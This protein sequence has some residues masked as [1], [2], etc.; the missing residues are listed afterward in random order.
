MK[1]HLIGLVALLTLGASGAASAQTMSYAEAG[2]LIAKSC[3]PSIEKYC[4]KLNIGTGQ[5]QQCLQ[6]NKANVPAQCF[7]DYTAVVTSIQKRVAAQHG[8]YK[9]CE[10]DIRQFCKGVKPGDA[11]ILDCLLTSV[12]VVD[13]ACKQVIADAGWQ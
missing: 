9:I 6:D 7:T 5:V 3:G 13:A 11:N 8:A 4:S 2:A 1:R 12:K 10:A